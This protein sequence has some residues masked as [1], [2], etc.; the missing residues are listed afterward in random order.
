VTWQYVNGGWLSAART[1][2]RGPLLMTI[3]GFQVCSASN[4][5]PGGAACCC[6]SV[7]PSE[8][9]VQPTGLNKVASCRLRAH[10]QRLGSVLLKK[11]EEER[12]REQG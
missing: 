2:L 9:N 11:R 8:F 5:A 1:G 4:W 3:K 6:M 12:R 10:L 7:G